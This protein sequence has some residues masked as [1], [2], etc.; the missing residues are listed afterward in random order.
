MTVSVA[1]PQ[2]AYALVRSTSESSIRL[3]NLRVGPTSS[4]RT[5][6]WGAYALPAL[7]PG[8]YHVQALPPSTWVLAD[9]VL[10]RARRGGRTG[11]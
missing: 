7:P 4:I 2:I 11:R 10:G 9:P 1:T 5:D 8:T 3:D 6:E